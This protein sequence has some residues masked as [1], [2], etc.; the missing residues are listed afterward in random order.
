MGCVQPINRSTVNGGGQSLFSLQSPTQTFLVLENQDTSVVQ[1][2]FNVDN[3]LQN[4]IDFTNHLG[5]TN[6]LFADGHV[7]SLKPSVFVS[8]NPV[9]HMFSVNPLVGVP[10][11][12]LR[13][14]LAAE[15]VRLNQ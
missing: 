11:A 4:N 7:K 9:L 1:D 3:I 13:N 14:A 8:V 5:Q 12:E 10:P 6:V 2:I 15:A